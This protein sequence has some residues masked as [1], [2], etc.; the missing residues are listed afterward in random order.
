MVISILLGR[1]RDP[2]T[3]A[4]MWLPVMLIFYTAQDTLTMLPEK[5]V[6]VQKTLNLK[7]MN[8]AGY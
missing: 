1:G 7:F 8:Y 2:F 3:L 5:T 4:V 6:E